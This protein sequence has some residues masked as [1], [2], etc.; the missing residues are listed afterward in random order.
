MSASTWIENT[1]DA[2]IAK[3]SA[4]LP[5]KIAVIN[6]EVT[7]GFTI[8]EPTGISLGERAEPTYPWITV[9]PS[10]TGPDLDTGERLVYAH[11]IDLISV[12]WDSD[13]DALVR[14]LLR[15]G[16]AVREVAL[17]KRQPGIELGQGGWG[18]QFRGDNYS[19][20]ITVASGE[21]IKAVTST[22]SVRQQQTI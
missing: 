6:G 16:R 7:D 20:M 4:Q 17:D 9:S 12:Y 18:L 3:L 15:F 11:S 10:R 1:C 14:K 19:R 8:E 21:F 5:A 22:F 2:M 13:E